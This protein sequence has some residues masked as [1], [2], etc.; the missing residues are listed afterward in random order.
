[1]SF[2]APSA[3]PAEAALQ[4]IGS[5]PLIDSGLPPPLPQTTSVHSFSVR[6][7]LTPT[8]HSHGPRAHSSSPFPGEPNLTGCPS[9]ELAGGPLRLCTRYLAMAKA[10]GEGESNPTPRVTDKETGAPRVRWLPKVMQPEGRC[11]GPG[12][13]AQGCRARAVPAFCPGPRVRVSPPALTGPHSRPSAEQSVL[14]H[15][16]RTDARQTSVLSGY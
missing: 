11:G 10:Q 8:P 15:R 12:P 14:E 7:G 16:D 2:D 3:Q 6:G 1:M 13:P 9:T 4:H 5:V